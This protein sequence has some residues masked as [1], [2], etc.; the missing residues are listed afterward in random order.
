MNFGLTTEFCITAP[1]D[2]EWQTLTDG[3]TPDNR[4]ATAAWIRAW[5]RSFLPYQNWLPPLRY[6]TVRTGDGRLRAV[7][8]FATQKQSGIPVASLAGFYW[9]FRSPIIPDNSGAEVSEALASAFT[10]SWTALA[11]RYGPVPEAHPGIA[12]LNVALENQGWRL[13]PLKLGETF[14]VNLPDTWQQFVHS[15]SKTLRT[16][17]YY[18]ER[19]MR[20]E[21]EFEI[22][23]IKNSAGMSWS[24]TVRD[25]GVVEGNSWQRR[26]GSQLRF[27]G[28]RNQAFW[29][30]LLSES[31]FGEM[32]SVWVMYFNG[33]PVSFCFCLDCADIRH[34]VANNYAE[35]VHAYSTGSVL[36]RYLF[37]DAV[38]SDTL[39]SVN[40]GMGDSGYKSRWGANP[41]FQ[42]VDWIAFRPGVRGYLLDF[43]HRMRRSFGKRNVQASER[44]HQPELPASSDA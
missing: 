24:E 13:R 41:S 30:N 33:E 2:A 6:L 9:P 5:G 11:L 23:H 3:L 8:P 10:H 16:N 12:S 37:R 18:Y 42:L 25:L 15:L 27:Y 20:R 35:H 7:F 34:I 22:R 29:T 40:I 28:E 44:W 39:R 32:V 31:G 21:G 36:Y 14:A 4:F 38:E 19:K 17:I 43:A 1:R 26:E